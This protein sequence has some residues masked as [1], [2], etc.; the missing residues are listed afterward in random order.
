[1]N[2]FKALKPRRKT[3]VVN[4]G[5]IGI[6][7][8]N[9][10]RVQTMT[11]TDTLDISATVAQIKACV[12]A[13]AELIRLTTPTPKHAQALGPIRE[14]LLKDGINIP[15]IADVHFLPAAA[16]E[17]LK[18]ADK[19][20]LNP[21]NFLDGKIFRN[22]EFTDESYQKE[23]ERIEKSLIPFI[24]ATKK[25]KKALRIGSNH[26]SLSDRI[27]SRYGDTPVGMVESSMEYL[28]IFHKY[29]FDDIVVAM[30]SSD[31]LVMIE[32]NRLLVSTLEKESMDY[33]IHLGV[34][35]AGNGEEGRAKSILGIG[36]ALMEGVGD[37]I[38]V[39]LTEKQ[40]TELDVC[41]S[42]LQATSRRIT[43]TEIISCPSCG[44]TLFDLEPI[45]NMIK[46][47]TKQLVGVR[48]AVMGCVV[49]GL[50]EMADSDFAYVGGRPKM[51]NLYYKKELVRRDVPETE[52]VDALV[53][54]IK[55]KGA[56]VEPKN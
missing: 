34:T 20:R 24:E 52:A 28:R 48:I 21:G 38:R 51:V 19:V 31:P 4:V 16:F 50:G 29:G 43:K 26:G 40:E 18:W 55:E 32:A 5:G 1:M 44:R 39:S 12:K 15:L 41:Y 11:N 53:A 6:G 46:E 56:W 17:A 36:T 42:I 7:G 49:N 23:L 22:F 37:T 13:G 14:M 27:M 8:E 25:S 10:V 35:H 45:T 33:P 47:R 3:R 9:P 2:S 30:K 54:L